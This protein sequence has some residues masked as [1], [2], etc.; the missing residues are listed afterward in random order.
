MARSAKALTMLMLVASL[1]SV[2]ALTGCETT[3]SKAT[4]VRLQAK[5]I[6]EG[7]RKIEVTRTDPRIKVTRTDV[8]SSDDG[9]VVAVGL[10]NRSKVA[11]SGLPLAVWVRLA[12]GK[13]VQ[14]NRRPGSYAR[15]HTPVLQPGESTTWVFNADDDLKKPRTA[16]AQVGVQDRLLQPVP[17]QLPELSIDSEV[18][19]DGVSVAEVSVTNE[20][21]FP[22]FELPV[23]AW[24]ER[25]GRYVAAG[26]RQITEL[27]PGETDTVRITLIGDPR[28]AEVQVAAPPSIFK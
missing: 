17:S 18:A 13:R 21:S 28:T 12:G 23:Y 26:R 24:A 2:L 5:R 19:R 4:R 1:G 15:G 6:M 20:E 16:S 25:G 3:M 14:V 7:R 9:V 11:L 8:L 22:Q 10:R 27:E